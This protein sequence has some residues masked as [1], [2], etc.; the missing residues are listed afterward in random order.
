MTLFLR[1]VVDALEIKNT[2]VIMERI[3]A[4]AFPIQAVDYVVARSVTDLTT[5]TQWTRP[6]LE[7]TRGMLIALKGPEASREIAH[8]HKHLT[9]DLLAVTCIPFDPFPN[10]VRLSKSQLVLVKWI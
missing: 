6:F 7:S 2:E 5:L 8:L 9:T 4:P 3:E 1:R 10:L